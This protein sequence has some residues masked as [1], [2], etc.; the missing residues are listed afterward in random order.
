M[1]SVLI[2]DSKESVG[3]ICTHICFTNY[4]LF[5]SYTS[6]CR[7]YVQC[8]Y[9]NERGFDLKPLLLPEGKKSR[10]IRLFS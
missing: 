10:F 9:A 4:G 3:I 8:T 2:L 1:T 5:F 6:M 7:G